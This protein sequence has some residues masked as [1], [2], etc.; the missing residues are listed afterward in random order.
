[1]VG[2]ETDDFILTGTDYKNQLI[3]MVFVTGADPQPL[4]S[5]MISCTVLEPPVV[6]GLTK[7]G[8]LLPVPSLKFQRQLRI[9][10]GERVE[11]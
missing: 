3:I 1:M 5:V 2:C 10:A 9:A 8:A 11:L 7:G 6:N 4:V